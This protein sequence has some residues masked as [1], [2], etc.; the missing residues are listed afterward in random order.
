MIQ[1]L[2]CPK[3]KK[4]VSTSACDGK[5]VCSL[6]NECIHDGDALMTDTDIE[7]S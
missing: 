5:E 2:W 7:S 4:V 6:C 1:S 3:C